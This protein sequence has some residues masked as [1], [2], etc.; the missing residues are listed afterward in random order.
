MKRTLLT[1]SLIAFI[2]CYAV[3]QTPKL[4]EDANAV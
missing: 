3:G 4:T 1:L 2:G